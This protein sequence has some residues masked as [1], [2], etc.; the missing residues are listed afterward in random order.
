M[1]VGILPYLLAREKG[2]IEW[3]TVETAIKDLGVN[4]DKIQPQIV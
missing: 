1:I 2:Q 4:P 3:Q